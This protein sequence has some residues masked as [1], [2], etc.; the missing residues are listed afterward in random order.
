MESLKQSI[1]ER[2]ELVKN[3]SD[4]SYCVCPKCGIEWRTH[5]INGV[6]TYDLRQKC[7]CGNSKYET[8]ELINNSDLA[9]PILTDLATAYRNEIHEFLVPSNIPDKEEIIRSHIRDIMTVVL[10]LV[11]KQKERLEAEYKG[12]GVKVRTVEYK[13]LEKALAAFY[14]LEDEY[15]ALAAFRHFETFV[16]YIDKYVYSGN[17]FTPALHLFKGFYYFA[18]SMALK[19]DVRFIEKQCFAGAGKSATDSI[20]MTWLF[21]ININNDALKIF[22]SQDNVINTMDMVKEIMLSP[23]YA[24][25]FPY[26]AKFDCD[27]N[28][29]FSICKSAGGKGDLKIVG[30]KVSLNLRVRAKGD[31]CDGVRAKFLFLDDITLANDAENIQAHEKDI[32]LYTSRWF[33]RKYDLNN[34]FIIASGTTYNQEDLLSYLKHHFGID[35]SKDTKFK[36]TK[37]GKSNEI[38]PNGISVFCVIYGLDEND[39]ST[40]EK[41]FPTEQFLLEREKNP[42]NFEAMVQQNPQ[43]PEGSPFDYENLPNTYEKEGIPHLPDRS[44]ELCTASLDLARVAGKDF[45]SMPVIVELDGRKY[46]Q[47][48][49]FIQCAPEK[50]PEMVV[51]MIQKHRISHLDVENNTDTTYDVLINKL[52]M[53]RGITYCVVTKFFSW[54]KKDVKIANCATAIKSIYFPQKGIYSQ[55]SQM[56]KF[57]YWL[58]AYNFEKPPKHDDSVDSLANYAMRF[59]VNKPMGAKIKTFSRRY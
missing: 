48:C 59:I 58:T 11:R 17:I 25:V 18:N 23:Q 21:G 28:Q 27:E 47:D 41:K 46:L 37:I 42:R 2:F 26:F 20:L 50:V 1:L 5:V 45:H 14:Q 9:I 6:K 49:I 8:V 56:G 7:Y 53:E 34:F 44:Q 40:F 30:S 16:L 3:F 24:N 10:P 38:V 19:K 32:Y 35:N 15:I 29:M 4:K 13:K 54:E 31:R 36:F 22:G 57:M 52:L 43:P 55:N 51:D 39:K 12:K 33:K